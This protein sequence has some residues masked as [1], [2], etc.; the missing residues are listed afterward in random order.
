MKIL[1][2]LGIS[3]LIVIIL[4]W[5]IYTVNIHKVIKEQEKEISELRNALAKAKRLYKEPVYIEKDG[6]IPD[7]NGF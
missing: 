7:F 2:I 6:R 1:I 4:M 5:I 3:C